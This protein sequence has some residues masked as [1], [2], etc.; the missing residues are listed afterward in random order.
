[1][2]Y[3]RGKK[4]S[5]IYQTFAVHIDY[6]H[7]KQYPFDI[8]RV[9]KSCFLL[10]CSICNHAMVY[11]YCSPTISHAKMNGAIFFHRRFGAR[12]QMKIEIE[13]KSHFTMTGETKTWGRHTHSQSLEKKTSERAQKY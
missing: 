7:M 13:V 4:S 1:M 11:L 9:R 8:F 6:N 3:E 5:A 10:L 12:Y 2:H